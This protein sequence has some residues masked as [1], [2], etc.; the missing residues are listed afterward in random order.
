MKIADAIYTAAVFLQLD[1]L[2]DGMNAADFSVQSPME[3]LG[4]EQGRELDMLLR[5]C[6]LVLRELSASDFPLR[7]KTTVHTDGD[8][9]YARLPRG[10]THVCGI[11]KGGKR[12]PF[13]EWFDRITVR[14]KGEVTVLYEEAPPD[15][16]L[17]DVSPYPTDTPSARLLAYGIAREYCLIGGMTDE[18]SIWDGRFVTCAREEGAPRAEKLVRARAW[19]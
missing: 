4:E 16:T 2:C 11:E 12:V 6:R 13:T 3:T 10:L 9:V 18:A 7:G 14:A 19:R 8:I 15:V 1:E 17:A 5:C